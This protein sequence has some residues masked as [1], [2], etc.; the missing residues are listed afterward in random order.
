MTLLCKKI[1]AKSKEVKTGCNLAESSKEAYGSKRDVLPKTIIIVT[2][3][4]D[5][6]RDFGLENG[7]IDHLYTRFGTTSNYSV[8]ANLLNSEITTEPAKPF[9]SLPCLHGPFHGN[10]F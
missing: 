2:C 7:F 9:S 5:Y 1:V 3:R 4:T 8:T 10:G 6:E